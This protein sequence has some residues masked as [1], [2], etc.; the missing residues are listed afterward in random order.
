MSGWVLWSDQIKTFIDNLHWALATHIRAVKTPINIWRSM[1]SKLH[2]LD[3]VLKKK[4][5][6]KFESDDKVRIS[7][8]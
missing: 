4:L 7:Q 2:R 6:D 3:I 1:T 5:S 8:R